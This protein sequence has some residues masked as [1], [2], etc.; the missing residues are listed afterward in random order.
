MPHGR[1]SNRGQGKAGGPIHAPSNIP[2]NVKGTKFGN[3]TT[4]NP[5]TSPKEKK[6][7]GL[8]GPQSGSNKSNF[9]F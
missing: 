8:G 4:I 2:P 5:G 9:V 1:F 3:P 7:E 6:S